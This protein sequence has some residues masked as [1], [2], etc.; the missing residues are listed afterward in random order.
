MK[1]YELYGVTFEVVEGGK[2]EEI[3]LDTL[4]EIEWW[5]IHRPRLIKWL[6]DPANYGDEEYSDIFKDV[7]GFR[8]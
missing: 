1:T 5:E 3:I 2:A 8:P 4:G 6:A 7:Y